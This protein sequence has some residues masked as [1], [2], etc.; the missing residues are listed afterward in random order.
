MTRPVAQP[1]L[2]LL[3]ICLQGN[4]TQCNLVMI[5]FLY[6]AYPDRHKII[7]LFGLRPYSVRGQG[8]CC[9]TQLHDTHTSYLRPVS[10]LYITVQHQLMWSI[11]QL[12]RATVSL[13][14]SKFRDWAMQFTSIARVHTWLLDS[15]LTPHCELKAAYASLHVI[16]NLVLCTNV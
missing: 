4:I 1:L 10:A 15:C 16:C 12:Y 9:Q 2:N 3:R 7:F 5:G 14:I 8:G 11:V 6:M 13:N